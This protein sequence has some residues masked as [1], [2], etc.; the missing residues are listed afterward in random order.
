MHKT[1]WVALL[2]IGVTAT[3]VGHVSA[4]GDDDG[5]IASGSADCDLAPT[6]PF[7]VTAFDTSSSSLTVNVTSSG[8]CSTHAIYRATW[9]TFVAPETANY[10]FSTC[11]GSSWDTRI[12]L[13]SSC[14][15]TGTA[16]ACNDDACS[17]QSAATSSL[18]KGSSCRVLVGGFGPS[19]AGSGAL[20]VSVAL[21]GG[22]SS[23]ADVIVGAIPS[24]VDHGAVTSGG[25][26]ILAYSVGTTSC[27]IGTEQL[28]WFQSPDNR[29]PFITQNM[30]RHRDG[31]LEQIGMSWGKHGFFAL[32]GSLCGA[33][34]PSSSGSYLGVGCSDPYSAF[35]N[36]FQLGLGTRS[37]VN[38][39][40]GYFPGAYNETV[41]A[42]SATIDR[43]LQVNADDM[44]PSLNAG[45]AYLVEAQYIHAQDAAIGND[46]NNASWRPVSVGALVG[47]TYPL[48]TTG[49]TFVQQCAIEAWPSLN[50][51]VE[52]SVAD[53]E[54]DGRLILGCFVRDN[55]N[56]TWRYEY[57]V[58]NLNSDRSGDSFTVAVEPGT[59]ISNIGFRD[60]DYHSGDPYDPTDW[61]P[62]VAGGSITW[63]GGDFATN[64]NA[65]ALRFA[66]MYNFWFDADRPPSPSIAQMGLFKP[67]PAGAA[68]HAS[69]KAKA[70]VAPQRSGD[71]NG[72]G[73]VDAI[74]LSILLAAWGTGGQADL[75]GDG[76]VDGVDLAALLAQW[77]TSP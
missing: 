29:H 19:H 20:S 72:D 25:K 22:G 76:V 63:R 37:E 52:L 36:G 31:R 18:T 42:A 2:L 32:Q 40:T 68:T 53:I 16:I 77:R 61:S 28:E 44:N 23:G 41:P 62:L 60:V 30:F 59:T 24:V 8:A 66:T 73:A 1:S 50:P 26:T 49:S 38:A 48:T 64:P 10:T 74:D 3:V 33:C 7:G 14:P 55:G 35:L 69:F 17:L 45:A 70:P 71:I 21:P 57:A 46:N 39:A 11:S 58:Q 51:E 4:R 27:N 65:N 75:S 43:R 6:L 15:D 5:G 12:A 67:G 13:F 56:G 47:G 34:E 54:G 9:F